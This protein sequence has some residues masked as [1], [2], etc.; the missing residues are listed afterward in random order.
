MTLSGV[1]RDRLQQLAR[2]AR[3]IVGVFS[4]DDD[5]PMTFAELED[6]S[7]E[8]GDF[9]TSA[10][11]QQQIRERQPD[12]PA[13]CCPGCERAGDLCPDEPRVLQTDRGEVEWTEP[14]YYCR[15]CRRSF[16]PSLG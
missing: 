2:E 8:V 16:F 15:H 3:E 14:T 4:R 7:I 9:F 5:R 6:E 11:L 13:A 10:M 1:Q 12:Q